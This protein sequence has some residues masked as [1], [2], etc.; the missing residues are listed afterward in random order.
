MAQSIPP[1]DE[2]PAFPTLTKK[3][4]NPIRCHIIRRD[5]NDIL[6]AIILR[7]VERETGFSREDR[8][9]LLLGH[10]RPRQLLGR[11]CVEVDLDPPRA[12]DGDEPLGLEP[13]RA[14]D[15]GAREPGRSAEGAIERDGSVCDAN[16]ANDLYEEPSSSGEAK[17]GEE[18][19][20]R[21]TAVVYMSRLR[22]RAL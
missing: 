6:L 10:E 14:D 16:T 4:T 22:L 5:P 12:L 15:G 17:G 7:P 11:V 1:K 8:D 9:E 18:G 3:P 2:P 21:T 13:A 19:K 20:R